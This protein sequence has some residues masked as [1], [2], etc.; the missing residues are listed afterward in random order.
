MSN[1][2][3]V[4][5][6]T[7]LLL[8]A[9]V[10]FVSVR[11]TQPPLP[12]VQ[13][14]FSYPQISDVQ[15][16]PDGRYLAMVVADSKTGED[17]K[18]LAILNRSDLKATAGFHTIG[19]QE[20]YQYWWANDERLLVATAIQTGS[21]DSPVPDGKL[22]GINV[23]GSQ[24]TLLMGNPPETSEEF[25]HIHAQ[26]EIYYFWHMLFIPTEDS[27]QIV[28]QIYQAFAGRNQTD[29]AYALNIYDG[30][31]RN[32]AQ[33]PAADGT[34]LTDN[35]GA[36][37]LAIGSNT[38]TGVGKFYYRATGDS[39]DWK[40]LS[41]LYMHDDP[42]D[43]PLRPLGFSADNKSIYW[44]GRTRS[45]T[46]SLYAIDPDTLKTTLLYGNP[47]FDVGDVI[48]SFEWQKTRHIIA[49]TS[50]PGLP[51][52]HILDGD[53]PKAGYLAS[54]YDAFPGQTVNITSNTRDG[55][56]M[57]VFVHSDRNPG[58]Y[59]LFNAKD[60]KVS[61]LFNLLPDIDPQKMAHM[62][63]V[64][65][66]ARDG[67]TL[68]GYLTL[69]PG[70]SGKNLPLIVKPHG[71]PHGIRYVWGWDPEVQFFASRG[72]AV[73]QV[74]YRGS[75]GYGMNFQDMGY[76]H[77]GTTMQ[78]DLA[79]AV[80]WAITQSIADPKRVCIYGASYGGYA[81][82][83]NSI[84][85]PDLYKCTVGY[86]G[87]YDLTLLG[88]SDFTHFAFGD[89]YLNV[90]LGD[91]KATLEAESP[92]NQTDKIKDSVFIIYGG[93]DKRVIPENATELM[94]ALDKS[95]IKYEMM[96]EPNEGHG[97]SKPEHRFELYTRMLQFFDENIGPDAVRH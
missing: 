51:A 32:I 75:G 31:L 54:L 33:S 62:R 17:R 88:R 10:L 3:S 86:V 25:T 95:G 55:S 40:D 23:D 85:Y 37:R 68:H 71:G 77:W 1:S 35:A 59:Y 15:I 12:T 11:A 80:H 92:V 47:D 43:S 72:Y 58:S 7:V 28:V 24:L 82:L 49:V 26:H 97:F 46:T 2:K 27:K 16:S 42:A 14:F 84:L 30:A 36:V 38:L 90:V 65:F 81:A 44:L 50:M 53:A 56:L 87:V 96:Y 18:G 64:T 29:Q 52:L 20:I 60:S 45:M 69:P 76:R 74:N 4:K 13:A 79:D 89:R 91:D 93:A 41:F 22:Y 61:L 9:M 83:E 63:P 66:Q 21:L 6:I 78:S 70:S 5:L 57:V 34:L 39:V 94:S 48:W 67:I 8:S 73:L 19:D